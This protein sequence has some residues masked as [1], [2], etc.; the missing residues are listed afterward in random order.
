[1]KFSRKAESLKVLTA[2]PKIELLCPLLCTRELHT[3]CS[4][5]VC[6]DAFGKHLCRTCYFCAFK[7]F[8]N[9][10]AFFYIAVCR[11]MI[12]CMANGTVAICIVVIDNMSF[13]VELAALYIFAV[14]IVAVG[15]VA[16]GNFLKCS[17][18]I[19]LSSC[20]CKWYARQCYFAFTSLQLPCFLCQMTHSKRH[21]CRCQS[22]FEPIL[23]VI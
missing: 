23:C 16:N 4:R 1:M 14:V 10:F 5:A 21:R 20:R 2:R 12:G 13:F 9:R 7:L 18:C 19:F 15:I 22:P 8:R 6:C 11:L 17:C 3:V